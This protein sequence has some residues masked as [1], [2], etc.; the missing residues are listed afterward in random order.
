MKNRDHCTAQHRTAFRDD[1]DRPL[2]LQRF[3]QIIVPNN[4]FI[5]PKDVT[6]PSCLGTVPGPRISDNARVDRLP[7]KRKLDIRADRTAT[8]PTKFVRTA[9]TLGPKYQPTPISG[10]VRKEDTGRPIQDF[11]ELS[12][13]DVLK[14]FYLNEH[15]I[16]VL[17]RR[18]K[19]LKAELKKRELAEEATR[20]T[21]LE[22][23]ETTIHN[24][25]DQLR[26]KERELR[27]LHAEKTAVPVFRES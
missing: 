8:P 21:Q 22:D 5:D 10:A 16:L 13:P 3:P 1:A 11:S 12:R 19:A 23:Q 25:R 9:D 14:E 18:G 26:T 17:Q 15:R 6:I 4:Q 7:L 2:Q 20:K 27:H 24:L